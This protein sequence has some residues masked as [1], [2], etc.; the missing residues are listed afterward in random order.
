MKIS[1]VLDTFGGGGKERRCLQLIQGLNLKGYLDIQV[2]IINDTIAYP[3]LFETQSSIHLIDRK[4]RGLNFRETKREVKD[5]FKQFKPDIVQSWG[6]ISTLI[7]ILLKPCFSYKLI[8]AY[9][10]NVFTPKW[11]SLTNLYPLFCNRIVGNSQAGLMAYHIPKRKA[12]LI[13]NGF[14]EQ[15]LE[16]KVDT[17]LKKRELGIDT[18]YVVAMIATFWPN[19]DW[20]CYLNAA[21]SIVKERKDIIFLAIGEGPSLEEHKRMISADEE[22][23]IRFLG[24]R[25]DIDEILQVCSL[26]VLT[27]PRGEGISNSILESMAFG[28]PVIATNM[29]GTPEIVHDSINGFLLEE[30][31]PIELKTRILSL[32]NDE[33]RLK[34]YSIAAKTTV[35][36]SFSLDRVTGKYIRLYQELSNQ[37]V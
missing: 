8:G 7:P 23:L 5:L 2:I 13:Y 22:S 25:D 6:G 35:Q 27:S 12:V 15:R 34:D 16:N 3:A 30:N 36:N 31:D 17:I 19:K 4:K 29:G 11:N 37:L 32:I 1:F 9:V 26:T 33:V 24:R 28:V 18:P 20:K 10:A 14:N 21:K